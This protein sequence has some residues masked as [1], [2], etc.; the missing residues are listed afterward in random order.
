MNYLKCSLVTGALIALMMGV[1]GA[2]MANSDEE[3][4]ASRTGAT[5]CSL[6]EELICHAAVDNLNGP[7]G[8]PT[9][10]YLLGGH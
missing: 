8:K 9:H 10:S 7:G 6:L 1:S 5:S 2:A 3:Q 4:L